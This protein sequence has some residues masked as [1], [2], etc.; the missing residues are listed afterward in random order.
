ML[1]QDISAELQV[2]TVAFKGNVSSMK[3]HTLQ[4]MN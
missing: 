4:S 2:I 1:V 3:L